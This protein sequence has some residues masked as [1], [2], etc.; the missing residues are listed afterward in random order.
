MTS[1]APLIDVSVRTMKTG[2]GEIS[3]LADTGTDICA[4]PLSSL[5]KRPKMRRCWTRPTTAGGQRLNV[6]GCFDGQ[7]T[8]GDLSHKTPIYVI[9]DLQL[10]VL[11]RSACIALKLVPA[12]F[13]NPMLSVV[14][15][16]ND[17][18]ASHDD[19]LREYADVFTENVSLM[20]GE[21]FTIKLKEGARPFC[22]NH[23]RRVAEPLKDKL[24][25][26]LD[27]LEAQGI[28]EPVTEPTEW[29]APITVQPKKNGAVRLCVDL[30]KLNQYVVRER[31]QSPTPLEVVSN[32]PKNAKF[33]TT[34]DA[35]KGYHQIPLDPDSQALT[36]F[37]TPFKRYMFKRAPFGISSISEHYNRRM[38]EIIAELKNTRHVVDDVIIADSDLDEHI[39]NVRAFLQKCRENGVALNAAKFRFAR[40]EVTF[41]GFNVNSKGFTVDGEMLKAIRDFPEPKNR[42]DLRSW[43]GLVNQ[44]TAFTDELAGLLEP[45]RPLLREVNDFVWLDVHRSCFEKAKSALCEVPYLAYYSPVRKTAL[46]TDASRINGLGFVMKQQQDDGSWRVVRAGSR[47]L[48]DAESRYAM[49]ELELLSIAWAMAKCRLMLEG[50]PHFEVITDHRPLL[51]ILNKYTLDQ[52]ENR[53]LQRLRQKLD[54]YNFTA[55]RISTKENLLADALSRNPV[56]Q[57]AEED[58][59]GEDLKICALSEASDVASIRRSAEDDEE[60]KTLLRTVKEGFPEHKLQLPAALRPYWDVRDRLSLDDGLILCGCRLIVPR[61]LR[62]QVLQ[63]LLLMHQGATK[64]RERAKLSFY[65]PRL[66]ADIEAAALS[67]ASCQ[68]TLPSLPKEPL[69]ERQQATRAFEAVHADFFSF[70][71]KHY[72]VYVDE[73]SGWPSLDSFGTSAT[74]TALINVLRNRFC[75]KSVPVRLYTDGGPQFRSEA[76]A[77]FLKAWGV[78]HVVSSPHFPQSNGLAEAAVKSLKKIVRGAC[79]NNVVDW[80]KVSRGL[81]LYCNTPRYNGASPAQLLFG[82]PIRDLL[83]AHRRAFDPAWQKSADELEKRAALVKEHAVEKYNATAKHLPSLKPGD[84]VVLQDP[85]SKRWERCGVVTETGKHRDYL[86]KVASGRVLRRNRRFLRRRTVN[87]PPEPGPDSEQPPPDLDKETQP[88]EGRSRSG[89]LLTRPH[90]IEVD[91]SLKVYA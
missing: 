37:I 67:C 4:V 31:W 42:T 8:I 66:D 1:Q 71:A 25:A 87:L 40:P 9:R 11:S 7:L 29:C 64:M 75:Q 53:R 35:V 48:S 46:Y 21:P 73:Y 41:A 3:M 17:F 55:S 61:A 60:Y 91:P 81:L 72:L 80:D 30:K 76:V 77:S 69:R 79:R 12:D 83:P 82:K 28:I 23:V 85:I 24:K 27:D 68:A 16:K 50:M 44:V 58:E 57:P 56:S 19:M 70:G 14:Q 2:L 86:I 45:L 74:S 38:Y 13:P 34:V 84:H 65:W 33:F 36:T 54:A 59:L 88:R 47:F 39:K 49:I 5:K 26:E 18:L 90:T 89:R 20:K 78:E 51:P 15:E 63:D 6:K 10:P 22:C 62:Q 32:L 52:I 43:F